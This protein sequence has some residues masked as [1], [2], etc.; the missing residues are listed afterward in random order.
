MKI[1]MFL[2]IACSVA[3]LAS[4][5]IAFAGGS[6]PPA[7]T[8]S[9][10]VLEHDSSDPYNEELRISNATAYPLCADIYIFDTYG[11]M[12]CCEGD[13]IGSLNSF[14]HSYPSATVD[15]G[16][17]F[18][19]SATAGSCE[20]RYPNPAPTLRGWVVQDDTPAT[21]I[22]MLDAPLSSSELYNLTSACAALYPH[23]ACN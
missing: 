7:G 18:V 16:S 5:K 11:N 12:Q 6:T 10:G 22:D 8:L 9:V 19:V 21:G 13:Y 3:A 2:V 4:A 15:E 20:P 23:N 1:R 17:V 14:D